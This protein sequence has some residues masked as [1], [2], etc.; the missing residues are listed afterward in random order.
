MKIGDCFIVCLK[1]SL[2]VYSLLKEL[3]HN[4]NEPRKINSHQVN[5]CNASVNTISILLF[6]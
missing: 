6:L 5:I 3:S 4:L 2:L 1:D